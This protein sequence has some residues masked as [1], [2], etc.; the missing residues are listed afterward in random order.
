MAR[1]ACGKRGLMTYNYGIVSGTPSQNP[2]VR[3]RGVDRGSDHMVDPSGD[4][5]ARWKEKQKGKKA[6]RRSIRMQKDK[7]VHAAEG[8][9]S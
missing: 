7:E 3:E 4:M 1:E 8:G 6:R 9:E 5:L 2:H